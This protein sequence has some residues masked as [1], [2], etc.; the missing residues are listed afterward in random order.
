[1][2]AY[3]KGTLEETTED[4]VV[5]EAGGIGY[6][7]KVSTATAELLP[8][9]GNEVKIYTYT[10]VR[11]DAFALFGFLTRDDLEIFKKLIAVNGIGPKGGL[12]VLSVMSADALRFAV[13]AGDAKAIAKAP[14]IGAKTAE[15]VIL[16]LRDKISLEDTLKGLGEPAGAS[17]NAAGAQ[18]GDNLMKREAIEALVALGYAAS[19]ATAAVKKVEVTEDTTSETILKLALKHIF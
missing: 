1:M 13:M 15:R 17:G 5:V 8:G 18:G 19:D 7:I 9:V 10:L 4:S 14:G 12:A 16:E 11:E 3:I 2:Y 6:N